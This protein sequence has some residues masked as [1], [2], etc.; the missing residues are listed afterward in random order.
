MHAL[1][2][3]DRDIAGWRAAPVRLLLHAARFQVVEMAEV[4]RR[5]DQAHTWCCL[6]RLD[7]ADAEAPIRDRGA[8]HV[9]VQCTL[10]C[11]VVRVPALACDEGIV[12]L[13]MNRR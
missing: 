6:R 13:A 9:S 1:P 11:E 8:Q 5:Q 4:C 2:T 7:R 12:L 10:R 3:Q